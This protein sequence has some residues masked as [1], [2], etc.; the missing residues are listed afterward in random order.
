MASI[1]PSCTEQA[2]GIPKIYD[3]LLRTF[4]CLNNFSCSTATFFCPNI[5]SPCRICRTW[6]PPPP[7][8]TPTFLTTIGCTFAQVS[9]NIEIKYPLISDNFQDESTFKRKLKTFWDAHHFFTYLDVVHLI[10][11]GSL[12][13]SSMIF[14]F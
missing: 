3:F 13:S 6:N 2:A 10:C 11:G 1:S 5:I 9:I 8:L 12:L 14:P 7:L 4:L